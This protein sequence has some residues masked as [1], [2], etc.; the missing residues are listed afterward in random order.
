MERECE[1]ITQLEFDMRKAD[2]LNPPP[3]VA[4]KHTAAP[5]S[6][7]GD[8]VPSSPTMT[9]SATIH[10][11]PVYPELDE[12]EPEEASPYTPDDLEVTI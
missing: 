11:S 3:V 9:P 12:E 10:G 1:V 4:D 2:L 8:G 6:P 5:P 7:A